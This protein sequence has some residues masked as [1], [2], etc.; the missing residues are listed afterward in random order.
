MAQPKALRNLFGQGHLEN[1]HV[2]QRCGYP[3]MSLTPAVY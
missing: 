1:L 3:V 2:H